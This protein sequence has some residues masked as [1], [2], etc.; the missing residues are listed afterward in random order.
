MLDKYL[1]SNER[2]TFKLILTMGVVITVGVLVYNFFSGVDFT[3][4]REDIF[5][6]C[7][8]QAA[9]FCEEDLFEEDCLDS[10]IDIC[11]SRLWDM[12]DEE[13]RIDTTTLDKGTRLCKPSIQCLTKYI[14]NIEKYRSQ[15]ND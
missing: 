15:E 9:D 12:A 6:R 2:D 1:Y 8:E 11:T 14:D 5:D 10:F 4:P 13:G 7:V 3:V